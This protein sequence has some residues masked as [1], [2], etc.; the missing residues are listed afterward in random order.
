M[1]TPELVPSPTTIIF[2]H[3]AKQQPVALQQ[4]IQGLKTTQVPVVECTNYEEA[5]TVLKTLTTAVVLISLDDKNQIMPLL[6]FA[7]EF[8]KVMKSG[9]VR[10]I[11]ISQL[12]HP[13]LAAL[14]K[15]KGVAEIVLFTIT[16]KAAAFK[17]QQSVKTVQ[18]NQQRQAITQE[19]SLKSDLR[20][21][22]TET[23]SNEV[24]VK[25]VDAHEFKSD[26]WLFHSKEGAKNVMG[27]WLMEITGPSPSAGAWTQKQDSW[28]WAP[29]DVNDRSFTDPSEGS[30]H[31]RGRMPEFVWKTN[32]WRMVGDKPEL[33]FI[34]P[35][36]SRRHKIEA[37]PEG[38]LAL[39][40]NSKSAE[41][42]LPLI[43]ASCNA[44][45]R[46]KFETPEQ[47]EDRAIDLSSHASKGWN[48][49][50]KPDAEAKK[51]NQ[52]DLSEDDPE[53]WNGTDLKRQQIYDSGRGV[54]QGTE[55]YESKDEEALPTLEG[56]FQS[57]SVKLFRLAQTGLPSDQELTLVEYQQRQLT[58]DAGHGN[59]KTGEQ[60]TFQVKV[61]KGDKPNFDFEVGSVIREVKALG[62]ED[63]YHL[64]VEAREQDLFKLERLYV[65][66]KERQKEVQKFFKDSKGS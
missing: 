18:T 32:R 26:C 17:V 14:I 47:S 42:K 28:C 55:G 66:L 3:V 4:L 62:F 57:I 44:D 50:L 1:S 31:F 8:E 49:N 59:F 6:A 10:T 2:V 29:R 33:V 58:L 11:V 61:S 52:G 63:Q 36:L 64:M 5:T 21:K 13:K 9:I 34:A 46:A 40:K 43:E 60:L 41:A 35:D 65:I 48:S 15:A 24:S 54:G 22:A 20:K 25:W 12:D 7:G 30:W 56:D 27:R 39:A 51:W 23:A 16:A 37:L 19:L 53:D 38:G 45:Y